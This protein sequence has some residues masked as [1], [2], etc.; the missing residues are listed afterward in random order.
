MPLIV[1]VAS[2][3]TAAALYLPGPEVHVQDGQR[4]AGRI[5]FG[6]GRCGPA[7]PVY[8]KAA[9]ETGGQPFFLSPSESFVSIVTGRSGKELIVW[10][11]DESAATPQEFAIPVDSSVKR[12]TVSASFDGTGGTL[13]VTAPDGQPLDQQAGVE[14]TVFNCGRVIMIAAPRSGVWRAIATPSSRFW[15]LAQGQ[16]DLTFDSADF[17]TAGEANGR[18]PLDPISGNPVAGRPALLRVRVSDAPVR[19][20]EFILVSFGGRALQ[21]VDLSDAGD[22]AFAGTIELPSEPFRVAVAGV[23]TAGAPYQ[24][25]IARLFRASLVEV[26][27]TDTAETLPAG[28]DSAIVFR[29]RNF[30]PAARYRIVAVAYPLEARVEPEILELAE[31]AEGNVAV[32]LRVPAPISRERPVTLVVTAT[33]EESGATSNSTIRTLRI[34]DFR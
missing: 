12:L 21:R 9:G 34:S 19:T 24:R 28:Q 27:A 22:R 5:R 13:A 10:A 2:V 11:S 15:L 25:L 7:D 3:V 6:P 18:E 29:V 1:R 26:S 4:Q 33:S 30:G 32:F 20:R 23:D 8:L 16:T 14:D 31:R 17:L